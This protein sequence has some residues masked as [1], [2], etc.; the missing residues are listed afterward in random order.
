MSETTQAVSFDV[1]LLEDQMECVFRELELA[2]RWQRPSILFAIY[3]SYSI[4]SIAQNT[5]ENRIL[6][7]GKTVIHYQ[8]NEEDNLSLVEFVSKLSDNENN[9][10]FIDPITNNNHAIS[11]ENLCKILSS[12]RDQLIDRLMRVVFWLSE[13]EAFYLARNAP[14]FWA[15]RHRVVDFIYQDPSEIPCLPQPAIIRKKQD[16][17]Q[18]GEA[19]DS[20]GGIN[21]LLKMGV[22]NWKKGDH[23]KA[24]DFLQA[25]LAMAEEKK[26]AFHQA[27]CWKAIALV[28]SDAGKIEEAIDAYSK[29]IAMTTGHITVWNNVGALYF[30]SDNFEKAFHAYKNAI[31]NNPKDPISWNGLGNVY[32]STGR[33]SDAVECFKKAIQSNAKYIA[34]WIGLGDVYAVMAEHKHALKAYMRAA[35]L[36]A[37]NPRIWVGIGDASFKTHFHQQAISA[38]VKAVEL[39]ANPDPVSANLA[40]AYTHIGDNASAIPQYQKAIEFSTSRKDKAELWNRL[41]EAYRRVGEYENATAAFTMSDKFTAGNDNFAA[42]SAVCKEHAAET[43]E[44]TNQTA[45]AAPNA[46]AIQIHGPI[47]VTIQ[48]GETH[49]SDPGNAQIWLQLGNTYNKIGS[50]A[51][52]ISAYQKAADLDGSHPEIFIQIAHLYEQLDEPAQALV[53]LQKSL[54]RLTSDK[55]RANTFGYMADLQRQ[56]K[57]YTGALQSIEAAYSLDPSNADILTGLSKI[58]EDLDVGLRKQKN[59]ITPQS[60]LDHSDANTDDGQSNTLLPA[61]LAKPVGATIDVNL[62]NANIWNELGNIF[63]KS[64]LLEDAIDAYN[65]AIE[66]DP[67][68]GWSYGNL[69]RVYSIQ[70]QNDQALDLYQKSVNL[71]FS[72]SD[73]AITWNRIG[74]VYRKTNQYHEAMQAYQNADRLSLNNNKAKINILESNLDQPFTHFV[75]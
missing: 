17:P 31:K 30:K 54:V 58:Q 12:S 32:C 71:L 21:I 35:E 52:A 50:T 8:S 22:T 39:G 16:L 34:P 60:N 55:D 56:I 4:R 14:D 40:A 67:E 62:D 69:A 70:G 28:R 75:L 49:G 57:D 64:N 73:K 6:E 41:G 10:L 13:N 24:V 46:P 27:I 20:A 36:E 53:F 63:F 45:I 68:F 42:Y 7:S 51:K 3:N 19:D 11:S 43:E 18:K 2:I 33:V 37:N 15:S 59:K 25:A 1:S 38:Y 23:D 47:E 9:I 74:D 29:L 72:E 44:E 61:A 5:L 65:R 48:A 66:H 26:D